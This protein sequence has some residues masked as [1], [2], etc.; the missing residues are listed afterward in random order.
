MARRFG[1]VVALLLV[2]DGRLVTWQALS[3]GGG[4]KRGSTRR[5]AWT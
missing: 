3:H 1:L 4:Y 5:S 2:I